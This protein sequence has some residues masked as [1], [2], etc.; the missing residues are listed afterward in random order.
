MLITRLA[1]MMRED[2]KWMNVVLPGIKAR[3]PTKHHLS[4]QMI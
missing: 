3:N 1:I 4:L 2:P